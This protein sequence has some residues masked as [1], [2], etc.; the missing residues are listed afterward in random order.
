MFHFIV[1]KRRRCAKVEK[2]WL[3][4][5]F[6]CFQQIWYCLLDLNLSWGLWLNWVESLKQK[7]VDLL[8]LKMLFFAGFASW[9]FSFF[10]LSFEWLH[11][12]MSE[13]LFILSYQNFNTCRYLSVICVQNIS[14]V[15]IPCWLN[16]IDLSWSD[17]TG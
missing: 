8:I 12:F 2:S 17:H 16:F 3:S 9:V 10:F 5:N 6:P 1:V 4:Q 13:H 7:I 15:W 14:K 11:D